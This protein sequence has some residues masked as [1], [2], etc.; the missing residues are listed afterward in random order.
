MNKQNTK[1]LFVAVLI[2]VILLVIFIINPNINNEKEKNE[3]ELTPPQIQK[4]IELGLIQVYGEL[5]NNINDKSLGIIYKTQNGDCYL[6]KD[7]LGR[8]YC[9]W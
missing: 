1:I 3:K 4:M 8:Y 2:L 9:R 7:I 5:P 6:Y